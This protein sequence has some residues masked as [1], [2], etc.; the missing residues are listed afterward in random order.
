MTAI[1]DLATNVAATVETMNKAVT[2]IQELTTALANASG[3]VEIAALNEQIA[4]QAAALTAAKDALSGV[5]T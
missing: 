5:L 2:K 3:A 4:V 1:E